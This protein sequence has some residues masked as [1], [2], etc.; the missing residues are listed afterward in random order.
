MCAWTNHLYQVPW[1]GRVL[2]VE[3][4]GEDGG[5]VGHHALVGPVVGVE[6]QGAEAAGPIGGGGGAVGGAVGVGGDHL[7]AVV[8]QR[9]MTKFVGRII[10]YNYNY[11]II[12]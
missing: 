10:I 1:A 9:K 7:V 2:R 6:E 8:L 5:A 4:H 12:I 11:I 3:L